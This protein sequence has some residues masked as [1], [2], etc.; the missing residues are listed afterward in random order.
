MTVRAADPRLALVTYLK[1]Q[2][3]HMCENRIFRPELPRD[4]SEAGA[5][6]VEMPVACIVISP[7]GGYT[8]YG[9][10]TMGIGDPKVDVRCY[11][12]TAQEAQALGDASLLALKTMRRSVWSGCLVQAVN[13]VA[14]SLPMI[15]TD[16]LWSFDL[17]T[18]QVICQD[19]LI[20]ED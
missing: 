20:E 13:I 4:F 9:D 18:V 15:D 14:G 10:G 19:T 1:S 3:G 16:T 5:G 17:I 7:A 8:K 6:K 12:S 2:V 11:G